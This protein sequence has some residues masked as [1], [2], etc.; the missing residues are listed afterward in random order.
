MSV[1]FNHEYTDSVSLNSQCQRSKFSI[2]RC[3]R[4]RSLLRREGNLLISEADGT[5]YPIYDGII[6][7]GSNLQLI[8]S[9][10]QAEHYDRISIQYLTNLQYA[11]TQEYISYLDKELRGVLERNTLGVIAELCCGAGE[12]AHVFENQY[13]QLIGIDVSLNMLRLAVKKD[14][15][16]LY[17]HGDATTLPLADESCDS[18]VMIGGIHHV[19]DRERLFREIFRV[20]K[21]GGR[22]LF[23]EPLNDFWLWRFIRA[24]VYRLSPALDFNTERPIRYRD[25]APLLEKIG[26]DIVEWKPVGFAGFCLF[27]NSDVMV[28][29]R[30]FRFLPGIRTLVRA[31]TKF[32]KFITSKSSLRNVGLLVVCL[33][34]KR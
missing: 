24:I 25:T 2:L 9:R 12:V 1:I 19:P 32:D 5:Q 30:I 26:F 14:S 28:I 23:R 3:P 7:F 34:R 20:L 31:C 16:A 21:P 18:V 33:A 29:N 11:H 13:S 10:V 15:N 6:S 8:P 27:M 17:V 4:T 22:F